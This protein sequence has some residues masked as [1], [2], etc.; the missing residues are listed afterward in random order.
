MIDELSRWKTRA[1][2]FL[3]KAQRYADTEGKS[4]R[5]I[6]VYKRIV[7]PGNIACKK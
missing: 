1:P 3:T 2:I 7:L 5:K 6:L 4:R